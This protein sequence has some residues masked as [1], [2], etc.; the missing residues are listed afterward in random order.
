MVFSPS[1]PLD[2]Y[3]IFVTMTTGT[4]GI[5]I[6][7]SLFLIAGF[8][9]KMRFP[10]VITL[11]LFGIFGLIM[12]AIFKGVVLILTIFIMGIMIFIVYN[13]MVNK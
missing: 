1:T 2:L 8:A 11:T 6:F 3:H 10:N 4:V 5:F 13:K 7:V 9:A 12:G